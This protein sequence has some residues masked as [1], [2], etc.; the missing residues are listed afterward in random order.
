E[1][2]LSARETW[3]S[4]DLQ[5]TTFERDETGHFMVERQAKSG[6]WNLIG[7]VSANVSNT[8]DDFF[9]YTDRFPPAGWISYRI[10]NVGE[11]GEI[12]YSNVETIWIETVE[13]SPEIWPNP[14]SGHVNIASRETLSPTVTIVGSEGRSHKRRLIQQAST[15]GLD[16]TGLSPGIYTVLL[17]D[18]HQSWSKRILVRE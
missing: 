4:I 17:Q 11:N 14:T 18:D 6:T 5:W 7:E 15:T 2:E 3:N 13:N 16:L 10:G 8:S 1:I 12:G 9:R